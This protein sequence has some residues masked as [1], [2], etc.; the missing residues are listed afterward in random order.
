M[1]F[2]VIIATFNR[3]ES[4]AILVSQ[5]LKCSKLP[6]NIIIVDSSAITDR[7]IQSINLVKYIK[8]SHANQPYQRYIGYLESSNDILVYFDDDMRIIDN[9]C[10]EKIL[11]LYDDKNV[12][13]VQPN[14]SYQHVFFD[15]RVPK[16]KTRELA[17]KNII[18]RYLRNLSGNPVVRNGTFWLAG[19]RGNKPEN[20][21]SIEWFNGPVF[22]ARKENL[23]NNF[24]FNLFQLYEN[25]VGKAEDAILGFTLSKLGSILYVEEDLFYHEDQDDST[26]SLDF[27]SYGMRVAYS[28]L[29]LSFEYVRLSKTSK[30]LAFLH[31]NLY[32]FGRITSIIINQIINYKSSRSQILIGYLKGFCLA[33]IDTKKLLFFDSGSDWKNEALDDMGVKK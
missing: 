30:F 19:I 8:S 9:Q 26:Y 10:F 31:F 33:I 29:Y 25:G 27:I 24:N 1:K 22:S 18:F 2:D 14:F 13:G 5:I 4:L 15:H 12:V 6:E 21:K 23:Y 32:I 17:K 28:R 16:S 3:K 11:S 7:D 20:K